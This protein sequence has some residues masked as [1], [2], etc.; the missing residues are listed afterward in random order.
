MDECLVR[1]SHNIKMI[2]THVY[3]WR[4]SLNSVIHQF[5]AIKISFII[6]WGKC[7]LKDK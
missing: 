1:S 5:N 4:V 2:H 7:L 3:I 6:K